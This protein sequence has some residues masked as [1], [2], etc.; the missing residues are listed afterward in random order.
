MN[1]LNLNQFERNHFTCD[2]MNSNVCIWLKVLKA[3]KRYD[4]RLFGSIIMLVW[5]GQ[6]SIS[7][8]SHCVG[9]IQKQGELEFLLGCTETRGQARGEPCHNTDKKERRMEGKNGLIWRKQSAL[10]QLQAPHYPI[11]PSVPPNPPPGR[12]ASEC[13]D[14]KAR[15]QQLSSPI[16]R[17]VN[18]ICQ[19]GHF[20][21]CYVRSYR[22]YSTR[23]DIC[24]PQGSSHLSHTEHWLNH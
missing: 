15:A 22:C 9:F 14:E 23:W 1:H 19:Q 10:T 8:G 3:Q 16:N 18:Y 6:T 4:R 2:Q 17:S 20:Y 24:V 7:S 21:L 12:S 11:T 5:T 13:V